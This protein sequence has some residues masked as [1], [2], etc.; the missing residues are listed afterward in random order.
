MR[1]EARSLIADARRLEEQ[2]ATSILDRA[3]V[4]CAT[5]TGLDSAILEDRRFDLAVIDEAGQTTEPACW[6]PLL[7]SDRLVL[8]GDPFQLPPTVISTDALKQ[9]FAVSLLERLMTAHGDKLARRL[10]IQY[11]MHEQIGAFSSTEFYQGS[12]AADASVATHV[13]A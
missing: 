3:T 1:V 9:G 12:L 4:V 2:V 6:I 5:L 10:N 13:L 8:A 7:R 11:R